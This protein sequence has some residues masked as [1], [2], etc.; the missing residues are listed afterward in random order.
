MSAG[1]LAARAGLE[2]TLESGGL[3]FIAKGNSGF[4]GPRFEFE[5][6][7]DLAGVVGGEALIQIG[8]HSDVVALE[9]NLALENIDIVEHARFA[10]GWLAKP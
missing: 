9:S 10:N 5:G 8:C 6:V 1:K 4:D 3:A 7:R 2:V